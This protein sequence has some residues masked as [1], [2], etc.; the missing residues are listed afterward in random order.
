[1]GALNASH[2][3][4]SCVYVWHKAH[5]MAR[6]TLGARARGRIYNESCEC[7]HLAISQLSQSVLATSMQFSRTKSGSLA[8]QFMRT[9]KQA[10]RSFVL[11][12]NCGVNVMR[13]RVHTQR[14]V[15]SATQI[16]DNDA[17]LM[18]VFANLCV[19]VCVCIDQQEPNR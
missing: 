4:R 3:R 17:L 18:S 8:H 1:M 6:P 19:C 14:Q 11:C 5:C 16:A 10:T 13:K 15:R 9:D 7:I 12:A 2:E